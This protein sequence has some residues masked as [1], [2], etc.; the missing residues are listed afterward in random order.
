ML[1][2]SFFFESSP[3]FIL[4]NIYR[5]KYQMTHYNLNNEQW[6]PQYYQLKTTASE[7]ADPYR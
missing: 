7:Q 2:Y 1:I 4:F 3:T 5:Y 6:T